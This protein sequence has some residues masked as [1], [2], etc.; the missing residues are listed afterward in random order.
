MDK[1]GVDSHKNT[2]VIYEILKDIEKG[3]VVSNISHTINNLF[4]NGI[5]T[6]TE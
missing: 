4:L 2:I 6:I 5:E 3:N 1:N